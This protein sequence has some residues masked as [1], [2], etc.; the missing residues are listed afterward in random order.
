MKSAQERR[1]QNQKET[2]TARELQRG[3]KEKTGHRDYLIKG[4][5]H[6]GKKQGGCRCNFLRDKTQLWVGRCA[7]VSHFG[8]MFGKGRREIN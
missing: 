2:N 7:D 5:K 3:D 8:T 6:G 1:K 4:G